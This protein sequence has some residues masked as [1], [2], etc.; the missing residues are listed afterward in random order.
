MHIILKNWLVSLSL[1]RPL[2]FFSFLKQSMVLF[3][4]SFS[5]LI[6]N[7]GWLI[8]IHAILFY[9]FSEL[10]TKIITA[11][12]KIIT[13]A[14]LSIHILSLVQSVLWFLITSAFL[15]L[16]RKSDSLEIKAYFRLFFFRYIQLL[17][18]ISFVVFM[19]LYLLIIGGITT[20]P[21]VSWTL[22]TVIKIIELGV[23]FYWLDSRFEL[24]NIG[25]SFERAINFIFYN[26]PFLAALFGILVAL[27]Y[28]TMFIV[29][30]ITPLT[31]HHLLFSQSMTDIATAQKLVQLAIIKTLLV[32]YFVLIIEH[33][34]ICLLFV[35]YRQKRNF[36]YSA[37]LFEKSCE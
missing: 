2:K 9:V 22:T 14:T 19:G 15:L 3:F 20:I 33:F 17:F 1:L 27:D 32:K 29:H 11:H 23:V 16:I 26:T 24:I 10:I 37:S 7:F 21:S 6:L 31:S 36:Q 12:G 8:V 30:T 5:R 28:G 34:W 18:L 35:L 13:S 25:T 4:V